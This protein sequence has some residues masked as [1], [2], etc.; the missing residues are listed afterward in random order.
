[1]DRVKARL[2][3]CP[4]LTSFSAIHNFQVH[5][6]LL[7]HSPSS[8]SEKPPGLGAGPESSLLRCP[9]L[10]I[11]LLRPE[12]PRH[13]RR[14]LLFIGWTMRMGCRHP[15]HQLA[16]SSCR[17]LGLGSGDQRP[18]PLSTPL[19]QGLPASHQATAEAPRHTSLKGQAGGKL[20]PSCSTTS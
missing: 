6:Q 7:A 2:A 17:S 14:A 12:S 10:E 8:L 3:F 16:L 9:T 15:G 11:S 20:T 1:M 18:L 5:T 19:I 4:I 13:E